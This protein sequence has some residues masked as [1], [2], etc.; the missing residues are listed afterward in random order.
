ML[1]GEVVKNSASPKRLC[2][3]PFSSF[4]EHFQSKSWANIHFF[5]ACFFISF[6]FLITTP[7]SN[8]KG[9][10]A[11]S[12]YSFSYWDTPTS[13][14]KGGHVPEMP[15]P[16]P[17]DPP[18]TI[19]GHPGCLKWYAEPSVALPID[20]LSIIQNHSK[21]CPP[22]YMYIQQTYLQTCCRH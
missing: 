20:T 18:M 13:G 9:G 15:P 14:T 2:F 21:K 22:S 8:P 1:V 7:T 6:I 3:M 10:G 11:W 19:A 5:Y 4:S 12:I 16:P 17:L